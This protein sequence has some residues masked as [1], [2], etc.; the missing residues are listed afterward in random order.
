MR[1]D[2]KDVARLLEGVPN[3]DMVGWWPVAMSY[4][5]I[6]GSIYAFNPQPIFEI[7]EERSLETD[8]FFADSDLLFSFARLGARG[9]P[10]EKSILDWVKKHGLLERKDEKD[11]ALLSDR[12]ENGSEVNQAPITLERFR[13]EVLCAYQLLTLYTDIW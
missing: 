13:A 1:L 2:K 11:D 4:R 6:S 12:G 10:S 9:E 7:D 8:Q 5:I 3:P